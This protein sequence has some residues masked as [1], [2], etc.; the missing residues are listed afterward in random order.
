[1]KRTRHKLFTKVPRH[2]GI[3]KYTLVSFL[4]FI[5]AVVARKVSDL[6]VVPAIPKGFSNSEN[7]FI[8]YTIESTILYFAS[9]FS[10]I[11]VYSL[12]H[13]MSIYR[14]MPYVWGLGL[15][16]F[17]MITKEMAEVIG[18][19]YA[20]NGLVW[21]DLSLSL[22]SVTIIYFIF[23]AAFLGRHYRQG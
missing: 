14:F 21:V 22:I 16:G 17:L 13:N 19:L 8:V 15:I 7:L 3:F 23:N 18:P 4:A 20:S 5:A 1:M 11:L 10:I 2:S 9:A 6:I 12:F